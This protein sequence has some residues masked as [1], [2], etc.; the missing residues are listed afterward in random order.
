MKV[1]GARV[2]TASESFSYN[3]QLVF[4]WRNETKHVAKQ[5]AQLM[6]LRTHMVEVNESK[7]IE[8]NDTKRTCVIWST[9]KWQTNKITVENKNQ[10][11]QQVN[12]CQKAYK[13]PTLRRHIAGG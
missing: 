7:I 1:L 4:Q 5:Q 11:Q 12:C 13:T 8:K 3:N 2:I 6:L 9:Q 10:Q